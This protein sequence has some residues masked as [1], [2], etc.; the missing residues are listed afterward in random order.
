M[1]RKELPDSLPTNGNSS[2]D[3]RQFL[4]IGPE[5]LSQRT[6][7]NCAL[8]VKDQLSD[9]LLKIRSNFSEIGRDH[10]MIRFSDLEDLAC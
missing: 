10:F 2:A 5:N 6:G 8:L 4:C 3:H 1:N 9:Q 7:N